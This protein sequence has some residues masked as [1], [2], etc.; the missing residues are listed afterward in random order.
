MD[1]FCHLCEDGQDGTL[2]GKTEKGKRFP[3]Y[4][5]MSNLSAS[6]PNS[7]WVWQKQQQFPSGTVG[8]RGTAPA[9]VSVRC[10]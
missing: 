5:R 1:L 7:V 9:L 10:M 8:A 6:I 4:H 2:L 3:L